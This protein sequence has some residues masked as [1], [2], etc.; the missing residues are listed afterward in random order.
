MACSSS[1]LPAALGR[2]SRRS[3][4]LAPFS[5]L[6][7]PLSSPAQLHFQPASDGSFHFDT[8]VLKGTFRQEGRSIGLLPATYSPNEIN[9]AT[10]M[11]LFGLYRTFANGKRYGTGMWYVPSE[12]ALQPDGSVMVKWPTAEE[13]PFAITANYRFSAPN[14]LDLRL[15]VTAGEDLLRFETFLAAYFG[16][17]FTSAKVLV[18]GGRLMA[19]EPANGRWQMFP[20]DS[21]AAQWIYDGR[22][23]FP[24]NPV[25]WVKMPDFERPVA[26]RTDP[27]AGLSAVILAPA[28]DCFAISTP[29]ETDSHHSTYLSLFGKDLKRGATAH[30]RARLLFLTSADAKQLRSLYRRFVSG[31]RPAPR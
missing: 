1:R 25:D 20:R 11:G 8:G 28:S 14:A 21:E 4:L 19:A 24:P 12:A 13:R 17:S 27:V 10:S 7:Q 2:L 23:K 26:I 31:G 15:D 22:W 3:L 30:A 16:A 18:K 5:A 29:D 6:A 9:L